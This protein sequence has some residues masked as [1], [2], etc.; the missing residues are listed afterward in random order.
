MRKTVMMRSLA[1]MVAAGVMSVAGVAAA[2]VPATITHQGRLYDTNDAPINTTL[3]VQ[4]SVYDVASGGVALWTEVHQVTFDQGYFSVELGS[5]VP[6]DT[7]VFDGSVRWL[8]I[9]VGNDAEMT[10]R[11]ATRSV[12]YA[13]LAGDVTGDIN[14]S[15]VTINGTT[16]ID[17]TGQ[18]VGDPTGLVGPQG[19]AGADGAQGPIGPQGATG[20]AGAGG[21]QGLQGPPGPL[22]PQG[23]Q[24]AI[25]PTGATGAIG[26]TGPSGVVTMTAASGAGNSPNAAA[27]NAA[28]TYEFVGPT[29][30]VTL[31]AGQKA[32]MVATKAMGAFGTAAT[33]LRTFPCARLVSAPVGTAPTLFGSGIYDHQ[34]PVNTR[35]DFTT[36]W[37]FPNG[38]GGLTVG[39]AYN[40]GMCVGFA[41]AGQNVNWNNNEYGVTTVLVATSN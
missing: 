37:S 16:V 39:Q 2:Q 12:P 26:P 28:A 22:G 6:F 8:G 7:T 31:Q 14:P 30:Q 10:P 1:A 9:T 24:G 35:V 34:V 29:V 23:P 3:S 13:L 19:P 36:S 11:A 20:A 38:A 18:W 4:F 25:G 5:T 41:A 33:G 40:V 17:S 15:S 27:F 32:Q 21:P